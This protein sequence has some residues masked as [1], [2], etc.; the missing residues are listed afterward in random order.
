MCILHMQSTYI[1]VCDPL[2]LFGL[3]LSAHPFVEPFLN[4]DNCLGWAGQLG[5][6]TRL[7]GSKVIQY[8]TM[9]QSE[10]RARLLTK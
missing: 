5:V 9:A 3:W 8:H 1:H 2:T 10:D 6:A 7:G 4:H